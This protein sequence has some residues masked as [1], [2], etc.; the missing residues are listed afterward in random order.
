MTLIR[1]FVTWGVKHPKPPP[2]ADEI[3]HLIAVLLGCAVA[4]LSLS[5]AC[6]LLCRGHR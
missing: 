4:P 3:R 2:H 6:A 1:V 5:S